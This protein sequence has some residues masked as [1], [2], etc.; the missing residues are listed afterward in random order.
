MV[1]AAA[2]PQSQHPVRPVQGE[3]V[4]RPEP[5]TAAPGPARG[6]D[7]VGETKVTDVAFGLRAGVV[8]GIQEVRDPRDRPG[9]GDRRA[10]HAGEAE[11][12]G[13]MRHRP[14]A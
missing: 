3:D 6:D 4:E 13:Q 5:A 12:S 7:P 11:R 9:S 8:G 14:A 10:G 1:E 2:A